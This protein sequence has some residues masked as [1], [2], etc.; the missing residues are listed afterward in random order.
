MIIKVPISLKPNFLRDPEN[1]LRDIACV[2]TDSVKPFIRKRSK[3]AELAERAHRNPFDEDHLAFDDDFICQDD[4]FRY[5]HIDLGYK[6]DAVGISMC[7]A[8]YFVDGVRIHPLAVEASTNK[9]D[10]QPFIYF[11]FLGRIKANKGEEIILGDVRQIIYDLADRGF[12]FNL[13]TYDGFQSVDSIQILRSQGYKVAR[14]SIDRTSTKVVIKKERK[15]EIDNNEEAWGLK[16]IST[17]GKILAAYDG[18][19]IAL[20][21]DRLQIP[22][23]E[24]W[25]KEARGAEIDYK[26]M[27]VDHK[28]RGTIDLFQ[29]IAGSAFNLINNELEYI[30]DYD[31]DT[32]NKEYADDRY[33]SLSDDGWDTDRDYLYDGQDPTFN[34]PSN[35]RR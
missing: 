5:M 28:P 27:K 25:E 2:P 12:T 20:Y 29:S 35:G 10:R 23:H 1:F 22:Y 13:I 33:S 34:P 21:E 11:D 26:K 7:H 14:L 24:Y 6:T 3:I 18:L 32:Y 31:E 17:D 8:P 15:K 16:R 30:E 9:K 4:F 19:R